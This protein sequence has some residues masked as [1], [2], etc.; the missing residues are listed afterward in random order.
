MRGARSSRTKTDWPWGG[1]ESAV[2][3]YSAQAGQ[4]RAGQGTAMIWKRTPR[5][6]MESLNAAGHT[7]SEPNLTSLVPAGRS[8]F[9][10]P[11]TR[12]TRPH[13]IKPIYR[14]LRLREAR[15]SLERR[16]DP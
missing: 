9:S 15:A 14:L 12:T 13:S 11:A 8:V 16:S 2:G 5:G 6:Q 10:P 3:L 7:R 4:G 1:Q